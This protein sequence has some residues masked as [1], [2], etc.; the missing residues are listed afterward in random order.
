MLC[1]CLFT[2][3][4]LCVTGMANIIT[5]SILIF[6]VWPVH[7]FWWCQK[8]KD[9][10]D[11]VWVSL[12]S[13]KLTSKIFF[14]A[15]VT[16]MFGTNI[17]LP[18]MVI[19]FVIIKNGKIVDPILYK[20][21]IITNTN[22]LVHMFL[23][24]LGVVDRIRKILINLAWITKYENNVLERFSGSTYVL[25]QYFRTV[26]GTVSSAADWPGLE[27]HKRTWSTSEQLGEQF[28]EVSRVWS[29]K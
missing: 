24:E 6:Y 7:L 11:L 3:T 13:V 4:C 19:W 1:L 21:L 28:W 22:V 26:L 12:P 5:A 14:Y 27:E 20:V 2:V 25:E 15:Y 16:W 10:Y 29:D 8:G 9:E 23:L 18:F 17:F